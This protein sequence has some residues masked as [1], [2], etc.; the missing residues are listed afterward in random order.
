M[1][2]YTHQNNQDSLVIFNYH[3]SHSIIRSAEK[4][5]TIESMSHPLDARQAKPIANVASLFDTTCKIADHRR[6]LL[7]C[8]CLNRAY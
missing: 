3:T 5:F 7:K 8:V 1:Q 2:T 4:P 6:Y